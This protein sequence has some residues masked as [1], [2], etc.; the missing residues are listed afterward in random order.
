MRNITAIFT[1]LLLAQKL[2]GQGF[3]PATPDTLSLKSTQKHQSFAGSL[4][5]RY[6]K[7]YYKVASEKDSVIYYAWGD[8]NTICSFRQSFEREIVYEVWECSEGGGISEQITFPKMDNNTAKKFVD[9]LFYDKWNT[10]VSDFTYEPVG[11]GCDYNI[12]QR[13]NKTVILIYCG[14]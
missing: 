13:E 4:G 10:W 11:P 3:I 9:L 7:K 6:L 5:Y 2:Y 1:V 14:C 12:Q 8:S